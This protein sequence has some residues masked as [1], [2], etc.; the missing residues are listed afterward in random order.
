[1]RQRVGQQRYS[2]ELN[3]RIT[4]TAGPG[5]YETVRVN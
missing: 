4:Y 1:M 3:P 2:P 5:L